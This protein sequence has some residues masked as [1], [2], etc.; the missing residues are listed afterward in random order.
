[1]DDFFNSQKNIYLFQYLDR[2]LSLFRKHWEIDEEFVRSELKLQSHPVVI[3]MTFQFC[4]KL[5]RSK[6]AA[7]IQDVFHS[8]QNQVMHIFPLL[9]YNF[10]SIWPLISH[11]PNIT[12]A[13]LEFNLIIFLPVVSIL[14]TSNLSDAISHLQRKQRLFKKFQCLVKI[15]FLK[16]NLHFSFSV[17]MFIRCI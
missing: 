1:M 13:L 7:S 2:G 6:N 4:Q 3:N 5:T 9:D 11:G 12:F 10:E 16:N 17:M 15:K 14:C 8:L